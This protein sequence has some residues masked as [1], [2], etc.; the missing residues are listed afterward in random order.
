METNTVT[1]E[2]FGSLFVFFYKVKHTLNI[3]IAQ[4]LCPWVFIKAY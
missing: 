4:Q 1:M 2:A 3:Y